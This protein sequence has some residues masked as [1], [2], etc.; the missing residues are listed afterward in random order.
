MKRGIVL[1]LCIAPF[2][3]I[4]SQG[5]TLAYTGAGTSVGDPASWV[6]LNVPQGQT[7]QRRPPTS[8]DDVVF[9]KALSGAP[10]IGFNISANDSFGI[11]G[12]ASSFCRRMYVHGM[13][14]QFRSVDADYSG[15]DVRVHTATGGGVVLDSGSILHAGQFRL[16][17]EDP[18]VVALDVRDSKF[19]Y[20]TQHNRVNAELYFEDNARVIFKRSSFAGF[21]FGI[22]RYSIPYPTGGNVSIDSSTFNAGSFILGD[23][24]VDTFLNSSI[25][26]NGIND[27]GL[28]FF[29]GKNARF[30]SD[31]DTIY[32]HYGTLNFTTSGSVFNGRVQGWYVNFLQ[33]D[34]S[35]PLPNIINGD[36]II[37][38]DPAAGISGDVKISGNLT[39]YMPAYG[40]VDTPQVA[41]NGVPAFTIG[42]FKNFGSGLSV[43]NCVDNFCHYKLEFFGNTNSNISWGTG[44]PVDSL[45]INK[46]GCAKVTCTRSLYV[47]GTTQVKS[48]QLELVA[49]DG[50]PYK[51]VCEGDLD[52]AAGGSIA[53]LKNQQGVAANMAIQGNLIDHNTTVDASCNGINNLY[54]GNITLYRGP[55]SSGYR[56]ISMAPSSSVGN[57]T[58]VGRPGAGF[59]LGSNILVD[60]LVLSAGM[61]LSLGAYDLIVTGNIDLL[62]NQQ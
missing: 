51:F 44:F 52:I 50:V 7:P 19:G 38:E 32:V 60:N 45:V 18:A 16:Y 5:I 40:F 47:A 46:T 2:A 9:S 22:D 33:E 29:I 35:H 4:L 53:L 10:G 23:N 17:G 49:N 62:E 57:L 42:G 21:H 36:V 43:K 6:Q 20:G 55:G 34:A 59:I 30:V 58:L 61:D 13:E 26:T 56:T 37:T 25:I 1:L 14:I 11:G 28:T 31:K 3:S 39:G 27:G 54:N 8:I 48:G 24:S 15:A 12:G 41:V